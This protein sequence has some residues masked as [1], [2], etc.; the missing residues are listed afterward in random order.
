MFEKLHSSILAFGSMGI[1]VTSSAKQGLFAKVVL[2]KDCHQL[3]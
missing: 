1:N 3:L 2:Q